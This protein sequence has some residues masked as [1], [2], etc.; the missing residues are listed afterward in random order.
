MPQRLSDI[1]PDEVSL[2]TRGANR[3]PFLFQ[4]AEDVEID[5]Q[6]VA[7]LETAGDGEEQLFK[8]LQDAGIDVEAGKAAIAAYRLL[9][10][11][12]EQLPQELQATVAALEG[13]EFTPAPAPEAAPE[14][15]HKEEPVP[16]DGVP[17]KKEDGSWDLTSVPEEQRAA[18]EVVLKAAD[19][20]TTA[21]RTEI[22]SRD[23]RIEKAEAIAQRERDLREERE[24]LAKAE[25][26]DKLPLA[27]DQFGP[28]LKSI[29]GSVDAETFAKLEGVLT[30]AN[31][32][33][34]QGALFQE[35]G[36]GGDGGRT[37]AESKIEAAAAEI[38]KAQ[39][40]LSHAQAFTKALEQ[41]PDLYAQ[42]R[43]EA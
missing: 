40:D 24:Y 8:A 6:L 25:Q 28:L 43:Q 27:P 4:K 17:F 20:E 15:I 35:L 7:A 32:A 3:R 5:P 30:A 41:N 26:L 16:V 38:R 14:P 36:A 11:H 10:A 22:E 29:A 2:V 19:A 21:L 12:T 18:L 37:D 42:H 34:S 23:E 31:E 39:P 13:K 33:V 9:K 1:G